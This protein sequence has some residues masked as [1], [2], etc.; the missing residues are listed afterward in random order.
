MRRFKYTGLILAT[1]LLLGG[2]LTGV[3]LSHHPAQAQTPTQAYDLSRYVVAGGGGQ[4]EASPYA[5][6]GTMAEP[7]AGLAAEG[8]YTLCAGFWCG[9]AS[10]G[11]EIYLPLLMSGY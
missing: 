7:G 8:N 3:R 5:L 9:P 6:G 1:V 10:V 11:F 2:I 4:G